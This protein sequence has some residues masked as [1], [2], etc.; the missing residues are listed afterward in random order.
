MHTVDVDGN[1]AAD[2]L[3]DDSYRR[4]WPRARRPAL[5]LR[6]GWVA[7]RHRR[8]K[9]KTVKTSVKKAVKRSVKKTVKEIVKKIVKTPSVKAT[10]VKKMQLRL[11]IHRGYF[12]ASFLTVV[13]LRN[14]AGIAIS[15]SITPPENGVTVMGCRANQ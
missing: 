11:G 6:V 1:R 9:E 4:S 10:S 3:D 12:A 2:G 15:F 14:V 7:P 8:E 5:L 13:M